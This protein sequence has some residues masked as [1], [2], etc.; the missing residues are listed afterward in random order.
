MKKVSS[1]LPKGSGKRKN[2][3]RL[4]QPE[5]K[6]VKLELESDEGIIIQ[7][8]LCVRYATYHP[9]SHNHILFHIYLFSLQM[10][11]ILPTE[12]YVLCELE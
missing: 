4:S 5:N 1:N 8:L 12:N 11:V 6:K 9:L 3:P 2:E 10:H 7:I